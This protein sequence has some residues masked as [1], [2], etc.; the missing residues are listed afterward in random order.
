[1]A[2]G[3]GANDVAMIQAAHVGVGITGNEGL[4]A[5]SAADY[6]IAQF[7]FLQRL[8]FV[9]G[10]WSFHR[11]IKLILYS[12]YKNITLYI[13]EVC[14]PAQ[15]RAGKCMYAAVVRYLFGLVRSAGV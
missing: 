13:I 10:S 6:T 9:H 12:F 15:V 2:I 11:T 8:L 3:D 4:Q 1:L 5:A 14:V 7:R